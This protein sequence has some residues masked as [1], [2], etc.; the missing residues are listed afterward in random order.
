MSALFLHILMSS[1][2]S[3]S[4]LCPTLGAQGVV[5]GRRL[6]ACPPSLQVRIRLVPILTKVLSFP[7]FPGSKTMIF[8]GCLLVCPLSSF[9]YSCFLCSQTCSLLHDFCYPLTTFTNQTSVLLFT[10]T[11][12]CRNTL[13]TNQPSSWSN[14]RVGKELERVPLLGTLKLIFENLPNIAASL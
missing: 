1:Y 4:L 2:S 8:T 12:S 14:I 9:S 10:E 11:L 13:I 7:W 6:M 3:L 5:C